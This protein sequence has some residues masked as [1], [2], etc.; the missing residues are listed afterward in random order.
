MFRWLRRC[1]Y[2][3][4]VENHWSGNP[5]WASQTLGFCSIDPGIFLFTIHSEL[6]ICFLTLSF[7]IAFLTHRETFTASSPPPPPAS[8][9]HFNSSEMSRKLQL[10]AGCTRVQRR[11]TVCS[12]LLCAS[13]YFPSHPRPRRNLQREEST[14][15]ISQVGLGEVG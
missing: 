6:S 7:D 13:I 5:P 2:T 1:S 4:K 12:A 3:A 8:S 11:G 9:G 15:P 14:S 10:T